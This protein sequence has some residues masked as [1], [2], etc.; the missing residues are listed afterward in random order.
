MTPD[1]KQQLR[2]DTANRLRRAYQ[3]ELEFLTHF[4]V[5]F[6]SCPRDGRYEAS[7]TS[8]YWSAKRQIEVVRKAL[9]AL[10]AASPDTLNAR[11]PLEVAA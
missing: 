6:H 3:H 10:E 2:Q 1:R 5:C 8:Y 7:R 11:R 9:Y 4:R